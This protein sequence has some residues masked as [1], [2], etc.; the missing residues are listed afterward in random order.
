VKQMEWP[1]VDEWRELI[2]AAWEKYGT[3]KPLDPATV[4][5]LATSFAKPPWELE[6]VEWPTQGR[7]LSYGGFD[8]IS[9]YGDLAVSEAMPKDSIA[10]VSPR[11]N[12]ITGELD[13]EAT[14]KASAVITNIRIDEDAK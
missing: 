2:L 5:R 1:K 8:G 9:F 11:Y 7:I 12:P 3:G 13:M 10:L 6:K 14:A 4:E